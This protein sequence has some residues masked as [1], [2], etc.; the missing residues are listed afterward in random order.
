MNTNARSPSFRLLPP[1]LVLLLLLGI[2]VLHWLVPRP[3]MLSG[4]WRLLGVPVGLLGL[5]LAIIASRQFKRAATN[6][7]T[8]DDPDKLVTS[9][10]F[11]ISR[12]PMYLG[13]ALLLLG[14]A[15]T[16]GGALALAAPLLFV[17]TS[18]WLY[19]PFEERAMS[20]VF[21]EDYQ[22][23]RRRVRRWL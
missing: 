3:E 11:R 7:K 15:L 18:Q 14:A 9:G 12:N 13:F 10:C 19:I 16:T 2:L 5:A 6:I 22:A 4:V 17:A 20:R 21:G 8:F 1:K 23:Y